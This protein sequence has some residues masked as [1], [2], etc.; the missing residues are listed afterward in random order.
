MN[1]S[2]SIFQSHFDTPNPLELTKPPGISPGMNVLAGVGVLSTPYGLAQGGWLG[3]GILLLLAVSC[4]YTGILLSRCL[5]SSPHVH[6]Y[7]DIGQAAFGLTGRLLISVRVAVNKLS[8]AEE[9]NMLLA[10][11]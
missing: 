8:C 11:E 7:P 1:Q 9:P 5:Q 6:T 3:L 2:L 10:S 4:C